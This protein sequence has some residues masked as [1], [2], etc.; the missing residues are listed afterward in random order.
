MLDL[1]IISFITNIN[2]INIIILK[3]IKKN[4]TKTDLQYTLFKIN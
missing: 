1:Y 2:K 3:K 4:I